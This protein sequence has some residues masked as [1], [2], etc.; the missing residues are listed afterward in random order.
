MLRRALLVLVVAV[1]PAAASSCATTGCLQGVCGCCSQC[2]YDFRDP[3]N[4]GCGCCL[5][6]A[7][8]PFQRSAAVSL[9]ADG[10]ALVPAWTDGA[11]PY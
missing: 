1:T 10:A 11:M 7:S 4:A 5:D 6:V 8:Q 2:L 9:P 3:L